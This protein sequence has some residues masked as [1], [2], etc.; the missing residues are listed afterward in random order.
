[1]VGDTETAPVLRSA[2]AG[3]AL[4]LRVLR[5]HADSLLR[6]AQR[7]SLCP[8]D[9]HDAYQRSV[10]IFLRHARR[11]RAEDAHRWIHTVCKHEAQRLREQR[12]RALAPEDHD[13][14][15]HEAWR[16]PTT[17]EQLASFDLMTR[18]AEALQALK[19]QE[20]R[21]LWLR[22]QGHSYAEIAELEG[23]S[24]TKVNRCVT[25]GRRSFLDR[26]ADIASGAECRRWEPVL[27]A[28]VDGEASA[29]QL[30]GVRPHLRHCPACRAHVRALHDSN[31]AV[32]ALL[33][34]PLV[35]AA[36]DAGGGLL[37]RVYETL[38]GLQDRFAL[39]AT[40]LQM[41]TEA[42]LSAKVAVA[43]A[44]AAMIGGGGVALERA[45]DEPQPRAAAAATKA[46]ARQRVAAPATT[47]SRPAPDVPRSTGAT[48][49]RPVRR[50]VTRSEASRRTAR[51]EFR[52]RRPAATT[53]SAAAETAAAE[54]AAAPQPTA[55]TAA[56]TPAPSPSRDVRTAEAEFGGGG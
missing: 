22:A 33:P 5:E 11:L 21:A 27:S 36:P 56:A 51:T 53:A 39:S 31:R 3:H 52:V 35:A 7:H 32:A 46:A 30:A 42:S 8:D 4:V 20:V 10:E 55:A 37:A 15:R 49:A 12:S 38:T 40:K 44:G 48:A 47:L 16:L 54:F 26:V 17:D 13:F 23:W 19:P 24:A 43:A 1:M 14:D 45:M 29:Q 25:E 6:V 50:T 41:G 9:A 18:S 2:E 28:L 34:V